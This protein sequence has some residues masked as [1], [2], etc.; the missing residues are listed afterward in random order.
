MGDRAHRRDGRGG[1]RCRRAR[2]ESAKAGLDRGPF[3]RAC[4]A[5]GSAPYATFVSAMLDHCASFRCR[6]ADRYERRCRGVS[7][8]GCH[9]D[10]LQRLV[11]QG[12]LVR[13]S[14]PGDRRRSV[15]HLIHRGKRVNCRLGTVEA[16]VAD[17]LEPWAR[18]M[19]RPHGACSQDSQSTSGIQQP[20]RRSRTRSRSLNRP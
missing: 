7:G 16:A 9:E 2:A 15:L 5:R 17:A 20:G 8:V 12:L 3:K 18:E 10:V 19:W 13:S 1:C 6:R 11:R 4:G 14:D